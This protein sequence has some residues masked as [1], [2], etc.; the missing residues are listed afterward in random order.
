MDRANERNSVSP[1]GG[2]I[3]TLTHL[4]SFARAIGRSMSAIVLSLGIFSVKEDSI[5]A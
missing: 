3:C 1:C 5:N 4:A 2:F